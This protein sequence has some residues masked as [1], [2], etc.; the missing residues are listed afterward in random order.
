MFDMHTNCK[1]TIKELEEKII[2]ITNKESFQNVMNLNEQ[3]IQCKKLNDDLQKRY[4]TAL[5]TNRSLDQQ[6]TYISGHGIT[7][8]RK[9]EYIKELE[10]QKCKNKQLDDRIKELEEKLKQE[11][12]CYEYRI[13]N[14]AKYL[15]EKQAEIEELKEFQES[16]AYEVER[17]KDIA[18]LFA[19]EKQED[20]DKYKELEKKYKSLQETVEELQTSIFEQTDVK[21]IKWDAGQRNPT[22]IFKDGCESEITKL[23]K[24][25]KEIGDE[26]GDYQ[27]LKCLKEQAD[28]DVKHYRDLYEKY[29]ARCDRVR[30]SLED[31][32]C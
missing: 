14:Q 10:E 12:K 19:N 22:F 15:R 9:E 27:Q 17:Q 16:A 13:C 8:D 6:L 23:R 4:C 7:Q 20:W 11:T 3:L 29:R 1:K 28:K 26:L 24:Y 21:T 31:E 2:T 25:N 18:K 32:E 30:K 5:E